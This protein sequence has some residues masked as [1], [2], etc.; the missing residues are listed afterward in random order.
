VYSYARCALQDGGQRIKIG[1]VGPQPITYVYCYIL[2]RRTFQ[3]AEAGIQRQ[4]QGGGEG[5]NV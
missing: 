3:L 4:E 1:K 5:H 2:H